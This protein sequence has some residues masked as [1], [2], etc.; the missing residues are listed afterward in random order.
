[1]QRNAQGFVLNTVG[2]LSFVRYTTSLSKDLLF[3]RIYQAHW[4]T[5]STKHCGIKITVL[6]H[7]EALSMWMSK[8][9]KIWLHDVFVVKVYIIN[10]D[11][12]SGP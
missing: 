12:G 6:L 5:T 2:C 8:L 4:N 9:Y 11:K 3:E 1:M 10:K 7:N